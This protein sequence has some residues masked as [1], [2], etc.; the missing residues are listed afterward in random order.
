MKSPEIEVTA[1][2]DSTPQKPPKKDRYNNNTTYDYEDIEEDIDRYDD[3]DGSPNRCIEN[4]SP[5]IIATSK[6]LILQSR[7][8]GSRANEYGFQ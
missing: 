6:T 5:Q 1:K 7:V 4:E 3:D 2:K 8:M